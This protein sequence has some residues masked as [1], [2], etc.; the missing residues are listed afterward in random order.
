MKESSPI[1]MNCRILFMKIVAS[2]SL[3]ALL[4]AIILAVPVVILTITVY[5]GYDKKFLENM[6]IQLH[7]TVFDIIVIVAFIH[8]ITKRGEKHLEFKRYQEEIEDFRYWTSDEATC[9]IAGIIRRLNKYHKFSKIDLSYCHLKDANL[10]KVNLQG[11]ELYGTNLEGAILFEA[12]LKKTHLCCTNLKNA[13]LENANLQDAWIDHAVLKGVDFRGAN[14]QGTTIL[15]ADFEAADKLY[16]YQI[17]T[18][19]TL[20]GTAMDKSLLDQVKKDCPQ[21]LQKPEWYEE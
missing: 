16:I 3:I 8:F 6:V 1:P 4:V 9:R 20:Y 18:A 21:L 2:P 19:S 11:A 12:N 17:S 13:C 10:E 5:G 7:G 14:L 15:Y